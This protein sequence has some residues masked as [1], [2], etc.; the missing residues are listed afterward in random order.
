[1]SQ[2]LR[3]FYYYYY[4]GDGDGARG[5]KNGKKGFRQKSFLTVI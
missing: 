1:M 3:L 2:G 4:F 5:A